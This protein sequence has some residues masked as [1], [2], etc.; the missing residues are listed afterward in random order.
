MNTFDEVNKIWKGPEVLY[1]FPLDQH[2]SEMLFNRL[3]ET[4]DRVLQIYDENSRNLTCERLRLE[5]T[6]VAQNLINLGIEDGD[7]IG[8]VCDNSENLCS[9]INGCVFIGAIPS[10]MFS[11]HGK[12]ELVHIWQQ[13][14]P[15]FVFCDFEVVDKV[16]EA[17]AA[18]KNAATICTLIDKREGILFV[19]DLMAPTGDEENFQ[20]LKCDKPYEKPLGFLASS[21]TSGPSKA[22][23]MTQVIPLQLGYTM[24]CFGNRL[25]HLGGIFWGLPF[26]LGLVI[27]L[28]NATRIMTRRS[29]SVENFFYVIEN[30]GVNFLFS[31]PA[32]LYKLLQSPTIRNVDF[33]SL[34]NVVAVGSVTHP[35]LRETFKSIFLDKVLMTPYALTETMVTLSPESDANAGYSVGRVIAHNQV[36]VV[37]D[38]GTA[39]G[40]GERGE[41]CVKTNFPFMVSVK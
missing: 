5:A 7:V 21:G 29:P 37:D 39:L 26:A 16:V 13:T 31:Y 34:K 11:G 35:E 3:K 4:P 17:L 2:I 27:P 20:P 15:K 18:M 41:I 6:R 10:P 1:P 9:V 33:S 32:I 38:D 23:I 24:S 22:V 19:D 25:A 40:I 14:E 28:L 12:D 30:F 8:F 36:K